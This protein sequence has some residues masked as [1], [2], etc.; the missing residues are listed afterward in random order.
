MKIEHVALY[1]KDLEG[2]RKFFEKYFCAKSGGLYHNRTSD[3]KS[4]FLT[5]DG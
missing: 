1:V 5:F 4:Y 2:A 3:F